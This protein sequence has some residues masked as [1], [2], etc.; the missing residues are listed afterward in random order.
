MSNALGYGIAF[1]A[2]K[3]SKT[4]RAVTPKGTLEQSPG[5]RKPKSYNVQQM[6]YK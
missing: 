4:A 1:R 5:L 2:N 3:P 6:K